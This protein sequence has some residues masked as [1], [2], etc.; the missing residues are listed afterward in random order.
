VG[1]GGEGVGGVVRWGGGGVGG[2]RGR[3]GG[4]VEG[5]VVRWREGW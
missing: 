4:K 2:R 3:R 5:R 1:E